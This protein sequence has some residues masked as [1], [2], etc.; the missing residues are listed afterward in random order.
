M[1]DRRRNDLYYIEQF[2]NDP[3]VLYAD[4]TVGQ[5]EEFDVETTQTEQ[6]RRLDRERIVTKT[7]K[8]LGQTAVHGSLA[9][10]VGQLNRERDA[11]PRNLY[12]GDWTLEDMPDDIQ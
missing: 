9:D 5:L 10:Y 12:D 2:D 1:I 11:T 6:G 7:V 3:A 4:G 8:R